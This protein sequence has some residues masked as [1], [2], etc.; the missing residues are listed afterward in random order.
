[1]I[2]LGQYFGRFEHTNEHTE[3][4]KVL[5]NRVNLLLEDA[6]KYGV[7]LKI[8]KNT[9]SLISG[10]TFGGFRPEDCPQGAKNSPHKQ[11]MGV[12][13]Y[14]P[15]NSLDGWLDDF[16]LLKYDLYREHPEHTKTWV[17]LQ[18]RKTGSGKRTFLP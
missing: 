9:G 5:L 14:D 7:I 15:D 4:A 8:N 1:M 2:T 17:H 12:D 13:I 10:Q 18:T 16:K 11:G 3:N 6:K